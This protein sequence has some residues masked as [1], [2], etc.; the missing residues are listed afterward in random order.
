MFNF[1]WPRAR[2][3]S[4]KAQEWE[5]LTQK[6]I[7]QPK[8]QSVTDEKKINVSDAEWSLIKAYID[9]QL[10]TNPKYIKD[11][12][13]QKNSHTRTIEGNTK[14]DIKIRRSVL[15]NFAKN[16]KLNIGESEINH[17]FMILPE[18]KGG[19]NVACLA[20][21]REYEIEK[22]NKTK[23]L[24]L[25][26]G[27]KQ[28]IAITFT[29]RNGTQLE[30]DAGDQKLHALKI[31]G[32]YHR[33]NMQPD[34]NQDMGIE[35]KVLE[36][37]GRLVAP[38]LKL[39]NL[40]NEYVDWEKIYLPQELIM[41]VALE[42]F[43][44]DRIDEHSKLKIALACALEIEGL[45][46]NLIIHG[47]AFPRNFMVEKQGDEYIVRVIDFDHSKIYQNKSSH[48]E[49]AITDIKQ[50]IQEVFRNHLK[51]DISG[52]NEMTEIHQVIDKLQ[53]ILRPYQSSDRKLPS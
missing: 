26:R 39:I 12:L 17:S 50:L 14:P 43:K 38:A 51:M 6:N 30:D 52:F 4:T 47:D 16:N 29:M 1:L 34:P 5:R 42:T 22:G 8:A 11:I 40:T 44:G 28:N 15:K 53:D 3:K 9:K 13:E 25:G 35:A 33:P 2:R 49:E 36:K 41:G 10:E 31:V 21:R 7:T 18:V 19:Y 20:R 27:S 46:D 32:G 23:D 45:H 48:N 24:V 37:L